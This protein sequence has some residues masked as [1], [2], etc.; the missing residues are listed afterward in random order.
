MTLNT[1]TLKSWFSGLNGF[2]FKNLIA[3]GLPFWKSS[4]RNKALL[5][6]GGA[7]LCVIGKIILTVYINDTNGNVMSALKDGH[8]HDFW[9]YFLLNVGLIVLLMPTDVIGNVLKTT[10]ALTWRQFLSLEFFGGYFRGLAALRLNQ[11]QDINPGSEKIDNPESRMTSETDSAANTFV[12]L[13]FTFFDA[14][15]TIFTMGHVLWLLSPML[16]GANIAYALFGSA[17]VYLLG[18][19]LVELTRKQQESE[20]NLRSGLTEARNSAEVIVSNRAQDV[21]LGLATER[22]QTV[23]DTL[24]SI[25]RVNRNMQLFTS[26]YNPL[27]PLIPIGIMGA[28][29]LHDQSLDFGTITK[30][31]GAF[32]AMFNGMSV[33]VGQL[34][35]LFAFTA[36]LNRLGALLEFL[37]KVTV[38]LPAD[39]FVQVIE[40]ADA[41]SIV[42]QDLSV[43]TPDGQV[44]FTDKLQLQLKSGE[45]LIIRGPQSSGKTAL[46]KAIEGTW[47]FGTGKVSRPLD[48]DIMI[49]GEDP[50]AQPMT[51]RLAMS[52][53]ASDKTE[54]TDARLTEILNLV[55]L[56]D[57]VAAD[58]RNLGFDTVQNW[59]QILRPSQ[60]QRLSL[61]RI[62]NK[63]PMFCLINAAA[64][65]SDILKTI[66]TVFKTVGTTYVTDGNAPELVKDHTWV[67]ELAGDGSSKIVPADK[68]QPTAWN[69]VANLIPQYLMRDLEKK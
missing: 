66:Y 30:A 60:Q 20:G 61:A 19:K 49:I 46:L 63:K 18:R 41:T 28:I 31:Q 38:P 40:A 55:D 39:K 24:M 25:M 1:S 47:P 51:L 27:A 10:L 7:I 57:L 52:Y 65:D 8:A 45:S 3:V 69:R 56:G 42:C 14:I 34:G 67:L 15:V 9:N 26:L 68:Y 54:A 37:Q 16:T 17:V 33:L 36:T 32:S 22:L 29:Y 12:G 21:V 5:L 2:S 23:I 50:F 11:K 13:F 64:L 48:K 43:T 44:K 59:G 62:I 58:K 6:L 53:P 35:G 4:H